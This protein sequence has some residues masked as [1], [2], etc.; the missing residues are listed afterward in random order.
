M[1]QKGNILIKAIGHAFLP[2]IMALSISSLLVS[3]LA[4]GYEDSSG[5][6]PS[7]FLRWPEAG[8]K[9]AILV[10]KASQRIFLYRKDSISRPFRVYRASTGE[11]E[12]PK[13]RLNDK[14]TPEG[15]Y[16]FTKHIPDRY[17]APRYGVMAFPIDYPNPVDKKDGKN[18]YGIWFHGLN[19][20]LKPR[21][22]NGCIAMTN[23]DIRELSKYI[24]LL[25][26]PIVISSRIRMVDRQTLERDAQFFE[27]L[28]ESWRRDWEAKDIRAYMSHYSKKFRAGWR[29][30]FQWKKQKER[31]ARKYSRISITID[32]LWILRNDGTVVAAFDQYYSGDGFSSYGRKKLYFLRNSGQWKIVSETF[33][34]LGLKKGAPIFQEAFDPTEIREFVY[35]WK[36]AW[37]RKDIEAYISHYDKAFRSA[38][39]DLDAWKRYKAKL[40]HKYGR[41][42][43][44]IEDLIVDKVSDHMASARFKQYYQADGY[45]DYGLKKISL[46]KRGDKWGIYREEWKMLKR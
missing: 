42:E 31:I 10:D 3:A 1:R 7:A 30:W 21:D 17:L 45:S 38:K 14:R 19:K 24:A 25:E 43:I 16:F 18:G 41:I 12:G 33:R 8:S 15:I 5:L 37:E 11:N 23:R 13:T 27:D 34:Q 26:T 32:N 2:L 20:P 44:E 4:Y 9:Y 28:I 35:S 36:S 39:M 40:N 6:V 46:I 22:T 29:D